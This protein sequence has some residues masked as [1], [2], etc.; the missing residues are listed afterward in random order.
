MPAA[1]SGD[2]RVV[3][4]WSR[5]GN[6]LELRDA[7]TGQRTQDVTSGF[8]IG[9]RSTLSTDGR[10]ALWGA[11][12]YSL[13]LWDLERDRLSRSYLGHGSWVTALALSGN[14]HF[15][16]S[17][18]SDRTLMLWPIG[19]S[20]S[21]SMKA[22]EVVEPLDMLELDAVVCDVAFDETGRCLVAGDE[23]GHV[24]AFEICV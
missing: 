1:M 16:A 8:D 18:A 24:H 14:R 5:A 21:A 23:L 3:L 11:R 4:I 19:R 2:G 12:D 7:E 15:A 6:T 13:K 22:E 9:H 17:A 10:Q 20:P